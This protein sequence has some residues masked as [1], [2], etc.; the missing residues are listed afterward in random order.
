MSTVEKTIASRSL[1]TT[2]P[3]IN[4]RSTTVSPRLAPVHNVVIPATINPNV[5]SNLSMAVSSNFSSIDSSV[6]ASVD[7]IPKIFEEDTRDDT[8]DG[9]NSDIE[10]D[11]YEIHKS[12]LVKAEDNA[13]KLDEPGM[14][15][16]YK[17]IVDLT[18]TGGMNVIGKVSVSSINSATSIEGKYKDAR[19]LGR[20]FCSVEKK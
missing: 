5:E 18:D 9:V 7:V 19:G 10:G 3:R 15:G 6:D 2:A 11:E 1:T 16:Q 20:S 8:R 17:D 14:R 13:T 12:G 4:T